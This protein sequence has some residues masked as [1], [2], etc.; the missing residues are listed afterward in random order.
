MENAAT[1]WCKS[2]QKCNFGIIWVVSEPPPLG[3]SSW[4]FFFLAENFKLWSIVKVCTVLRDVLAKTPK[5]ILGEEKEYFGPNFGPILIILGKS[6][7][8]VTVK[9]LKLTVTLFDPVI[10][11]NAFYFIQKC[12]N[13]QKLLLILWKVYFH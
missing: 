13:I 6:W 3:A 10:H 1:N 11:W 12:Y 8:T 7:V 4:K 9:I 2:Q 5:I